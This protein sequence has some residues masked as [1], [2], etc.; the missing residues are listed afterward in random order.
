[1]ALFTVIF[2]KVA[3]VLYSAAVMPRED[4]AFRR[5]LGWLVLRFECY[6]HVLDVASL[7]LGLY[8][9]FLLDLFD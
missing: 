4:N 9:V 8:M 6:L 5:A 3:Y 2:L 1:M 7:E